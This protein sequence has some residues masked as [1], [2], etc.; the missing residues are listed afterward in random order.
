MDIY[1]LDE[2]LP[3]LSGSPTGDIDQETG[4]M[5]YGKEEI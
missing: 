1:E 3:I 5:P 4:E 2:K